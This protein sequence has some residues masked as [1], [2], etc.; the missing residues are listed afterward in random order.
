M[1]LLEFKLFPT[2]VGVILSKAIKGTNK[3]SFPHMGGG[4]PSRGKI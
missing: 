4:D 1:E 3:K 2:W